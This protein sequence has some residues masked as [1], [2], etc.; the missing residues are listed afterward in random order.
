MNGNHRAPGEIEIRVLVADNSRIHTRLLSDALTRD[1]A[2]QVTPFESDSSGLV[3]AAMAQDIDVVVISSN[4]DEQPARGLEVLRELRTLHPDTRAVLLLNSSKDEAVLQAFRAGARGIFGRNEPVELLSKCVRSVYQ[5][6]IW[7]NSHQL[8]IAVEALA[9]SPIVRA[10]NAQGI[11]LLSGREMQVVRCLAE[12]LTNREIAE[13]LDLSQHTVK[14]YLFRV[15]E[16]LGVSSRVELLFMTLSQTSAD[17]AAPQGTPKQDRNLNGYSD[18]ESDLLMKSAEAGL[19]AAQ[20]AVAQLYL[21]Q[22][23]EPQDLVHAYMWYLIATDRVLEARKI[24]TGKMTSQQIDQA[25]QKARTWLSKQKKTS[26]FE[27]PAA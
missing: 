18:A 10:V 21:A 25:T 14:N 23:R 13:R 24:I 1:P 12:G 3:A 16:K 7:A 8:G 6:Q 19:P 15:F 27:D 4:L 17:Q 2:L 9:S 26:S 22:G 20:L 11:N 5:N